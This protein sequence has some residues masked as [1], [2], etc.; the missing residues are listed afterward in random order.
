M[1]A[2]FLLAFLAHLDDVGERRDGQLLLF[3]LDYECRIRLLVG[4]RDDFTLVVFE[5]I[6]VAGEVLFAQFVQLVVLQAEEGAEISIHFDVRVHAE[7]ERSFGMISR[8]EDFF[9]RVSA[10]REA[11]A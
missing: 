9:A 2:D 8:E 5:D 7:R 1:E 10:C 6:R 11:D 3:V 4:C